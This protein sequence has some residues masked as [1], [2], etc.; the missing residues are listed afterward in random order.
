MTLAPAAKVV[1][2]DKHSGGTAL[3]AIKDFFTPTN[4]E[5]GTDRQ[6]GELYA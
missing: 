2:E 1:E 6:G 5:K 4:S 3:D